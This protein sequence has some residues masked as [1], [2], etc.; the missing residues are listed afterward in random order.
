MNTDSR[1]KNSIRNSSVSIITQIL[2]IIMDFFVK[3]IFIFIL[4]NEYLGINGLFSNIIT[5]LSLADLGIGVAIPYS[6]YKPLAEK[7]EKKI[8]GLMNFYK[9][10]YN[11]I[12]CVVLVVGL[13]LTPFLPL[14]IKEMP[15]IDG[16]YLIYDL[17][18]IHSALSYFFIYKRFLIDSDQKGYI[19]A[20]ITFVS[21]LLL[22]ITRV[23][24][25]IITKN[26]ILYL[27]CS[28][29]F[30]LIQNI[31]ISH[32]ANQ[33]Y[34]FIKEKSNDEI[35]KKDKD[36]IATN[37]KALLIYKIGTVITLGTDNIVISKFIGLVAVGIY[38]NYI[39]ITNSLN[40]LLIQLFNGVSASIGNL[41]ATNNE[42]SKSI[43]EKLT[44]FNFYIY[45]LCSLCIFVLI[46]PFVHIWLGDD[47]V[48]S[49]WVSILI[50]INFYINGMGVVT[51]SFRSAYGLFYKARFRP[52]V[53]VIINIV[54]SIILVKHYG[55]AGVLIG[56]IAS[57]LLTIAWLDPYII[58]KYGFKGNIF[59]YYKKYLYYLGIFIA[60][61]AFIYYLTTFINTKNILMWII[62]ALGSII[63][64]NLIIYILFH[65]KEEFKYFHSQIKRIINKFIKKEQ[66]NEI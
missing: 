11:I 40:N 46:N 52:I 28:I 36:E 48:L 35:S 44:F 4:G 65:K 43:F 30:I 23:I 20:H 3:T 63:I 62:S 32:K 25:L 26:F 33:M 55:I 41:V 66:Q 38:S 64:Y 61:S 19:T 22:N 2:T 24:I 12:G 16:I 60:S 29:I 21:S 42:R 53:M 18:V 56:T 54:V 10:I 58:Y 8:R 34:P 51:N 39:L 27:F 59:E 6:L 57:R 37:V 49:I 47:Y 5:L 17:F 45:S 15:N 50:A 7:D 14:I 31:W 13:S 9:K 1:T